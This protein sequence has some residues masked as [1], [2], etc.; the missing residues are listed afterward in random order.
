MH[1]CQACDDPRLMTPGGG[2]ARC[3]ACG[4][5]DP[6]AATLPLFVVTGASGSGKT[7]V[8]PELL[9]RMAGRCVVF[10]A[11]WLIDPLGRAG[12]DGQV[13]WPSFRDAWLHVAH[14]VAQNG[15]PTLLLGPFI[16]Q[17]LEDL[18]GRAWVGDIH[19]LV[20]DCPD[21]E[22]RR[23][24]EARPRWRARDI[25]EQTG[26]GRWLRE[27]PAPVIDTSADSPAGVADAV[28]AWV[29]SRLAT[30]EQQLTGKPAMP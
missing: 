27:N 29:H 4:R 5:V 2:L 25:D 7:T 15:L 17:H 19:Y 28:A 14:G 10:D 1:Y 13:D 24:I 12:K 6:T 30:V 20:L 18:P 26:F 9:R 21:G 8:F 16:P 22:R 11:D 3:P 23:R